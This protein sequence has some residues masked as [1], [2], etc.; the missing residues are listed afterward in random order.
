MSGRTIRVVTTVAATIAL[1]LGGATASVALWS[2]TATAGSTARTAT[3]GATNTIGNGLAVTYTASTTSGVGVVTVTN[4]GSREASYSTAITAS[5]ASS[6]LRSAVAVTVGVAT[7]CTATATLTGPVSGTFAATVTRTG[8][9]AAGASVALCVRTSMTGSGVTA[10]PGASLT[11]SVATTVSVGGWTATS[12]AATVTQSVATPTV[13][14]FASVEGSRYRIV[15]TGACISANWGSYETL[16]RNATLG[17]DCSNEQTSQWRFVEAGNGTKYIVRAFNTDNAGGNRWTAASSTTVSSLTGAVSSAKRW[18]VTL[19]PDGTTYRIRSESTGRCAQV[20]ANGGL[21]LADCSDT[22]AAQGFTF[23]VA[24]DA[25]QPVA[26]LACTGNGTNYINYSWPVATGFQAEIVYKVYVNDLFA[27]DHT[28][29]YSTSVHLSPTNLPV[30]TFGAGTRAV[31]VRQSIAGGA[32]TVTGNGL[33]T[34]AA[35]TNN[36]SCG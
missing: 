9:L 32:W 7:T 33:I 6:T 34:I 36:L 26:T 12:T 11:A 8:T 20:Q 23:T 10:N 25:S 24:A 13:T 28:N 15:N 27:I 1:V 16:S 35:G 30:G 3:V 21:V 17:G 19:R 29:G 18:A 5:S 4:T 31:Q 2:A 22:S 14:N